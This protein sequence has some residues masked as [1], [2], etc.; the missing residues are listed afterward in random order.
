MRSAVLPVSP[1]LK[2]SQSRKTGSSS[3]CPVCWFLRR[4]FT[5]KPNAATL[6]PLENMRTSGSRVR[7]PINMT[8]LRFAMRI[9]SEEVPG[10]WKLQVFY[11]ERRSIARLAPAAVAVFQIE[12]GRYAVLARRLFLHVVQGDRR[13]LPL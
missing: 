11:Q 5:A 7:R 10:R 12:I 1:R 3:H 4:L 2:A 8:L 6:P 13:V 9:I